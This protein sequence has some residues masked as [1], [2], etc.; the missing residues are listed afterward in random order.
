RRRRRGDA[1]DVGVE[2]RQERHQRLED[3]VGRQVS[4]AVADLLA[5]GKDLAVAA[6]ASPARRLDWK[7]EDATRTVSPDGWRVRAHCTLPLPSGSKHT[8]KEGLSRPV[9]AGIA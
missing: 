1:V 7:V 2:E 4:Q 6:H 3:Q 8:R 9:R 5:Y